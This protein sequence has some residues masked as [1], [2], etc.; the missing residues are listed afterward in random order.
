MLWRC[1]GQ[2]NN[3]LFECK[4]SIGDL[5]V[6]SAVQQS[7]CSSSHGPFVSFMKVWL[8]EELTFNYYYTFILSELTGA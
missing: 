8:L 2:G 1:H 6:F 3:L 4:I 7:G 5:L